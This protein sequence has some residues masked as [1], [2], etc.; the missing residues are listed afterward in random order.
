MRY[1]LKFF[2]LSL[3]LVTSFIF[4]Q[5]SPV[6]K[7]KLLGYAKEA[8]RQQ[9]LRNEMSTASISPKNYF[10]VEDGSQTAMLVMN[11]QNGFVVMAADDAIHP[12]LAYSIDENLN[13]EEAAPATR[14]FIDQYKKEIA[15]VRSVRMEPTDEVEAEWNAIRTAS[16][17]EA[18]SVVVEPLL[19]SRWNQT[20]YYNQFSPVDHDAPAGYDNRTP[21]GCVAVAMSQIMYYY[22]YPSQGSGSHTNY[23]DYGSFTVDFSQQKYCYEAMTDELDFYNN[24]VAKLIFH[25]ATSVDM[26][27]GASGSG[28]YSGDVPY[29]MATYFGYGDNASF[30]YKSGYSGSAWRNMLRTELNAGHPVYYSGSSEEGGH[31]FV[32]DGYDSDGRFHFNFGWGGA[33]NGFFSTS[34]SD[35]NP[36]N[37]YSGW[38]G[39]M[40]D[41]YP[42]SQNYPP[43]CNSTNVLTSVNGTLEDGSNAE[44]YQ[45]NMN[46][47]YVIA[48]PLAQRITVT[49]QKFDT[50]AD[51]DSLSFWNGNPSNGNLLL[52]LSGGMPSTSSFTFNVDSLY[53]T[54]KTNDSVVGAGWRLT[55]YAECEVVPCHSAVYNAPNGSIE[56][57][58]GDKMYR[59]NANCIWKIRA[60]QASYI[61]ISF[62]EFDVSPEDGLYVYDVSSSPAE[63]LMVYSGHEIPQERTFYTNTISLRFISDNNL[64]G[65]GF[66]LNWRTDASVDGIENLEDSNID[67]C[68]NP[69]SSFVNLRLGSYVNSNIQLFDVTG[70]VVL[71]LNSSGQDILR[72]DVSALKPGV[73]MLCTGDKSN[74]I[75]KKLII[76]R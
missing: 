16:P 62:D 36:V 21:N 58:S 50:E 63:L 25:A 8:F 71:N 42:A 72:F 45:N 43:Y 7:G 24:E 48:P 76:T 11:F 1:C 75:K 34:S 41:L 17:I 22:R 19:T 13:L 53:I 35:A 5:S 2:C 68:P 46:C 20:K 65:E 49:I 38:Q 12:V 51:G 29:A 74:A 61:T 6:S 9:L 44:P 26:M 28:A 64:T 18:K 27:Y 47:V 67:I 30:R 59:A 70:R 56:D 39:A 52:S 37:G 33:G 4:V 40:F 3:A 23:C 54:F 32:C 57:G 69:A 15:Y 31:A 10:F 55:Y 73:Y 60:A 14:L 66:Y